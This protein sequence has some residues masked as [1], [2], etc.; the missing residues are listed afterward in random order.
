MILHV[1]LLRPKPDLPRDGRDAVVRD[2]QHAAAEIPTIRRLRIGH[3]VRHGLPGYEQ[4]M[5]E[6]Y[7]YAL[8]MEFDDL[9]GLTSYLTHPAH[10]S[11]GRHFLV[12]SSAALAYDYQIID[13]PDLVP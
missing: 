4:A 8:L 13:T 3:R 1:V 5:H 6:D 11:L 9:E 7:E 2:L 10:M 12:S